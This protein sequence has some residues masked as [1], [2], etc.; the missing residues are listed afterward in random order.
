MGFLRKASADRSTMRCTHRH[1]VFRAILT[2][3]PIIRDGTQSGFMGMTHPL[4]E[5]GKAP[6]ARLWLPSLRA[7]EGGWG[8]PPALIPSNAGMILATIATGGLL[9]A[10]L[11]VEGLVFP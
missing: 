4:E 8:S 11:L 9:L 10:G 2:V 3:R 1:R 5:P 7:P 6:V